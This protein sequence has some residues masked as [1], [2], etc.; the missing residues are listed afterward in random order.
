M[1]AIEKALPLIRV[2]WEPETTARNLR[3]IRESRAARGENV[4]WEREIGEELER[5]A[6]A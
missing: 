4:P 6:K 3:L 2:T 5:R 1:Q